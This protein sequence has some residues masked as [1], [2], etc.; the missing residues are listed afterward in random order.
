MSKLRLEDINNSLITIIKL[1][2]DVECKCIPH[3]KSLNGA[4]LEYSHH[5]ILELEVNLDIIWPNL[6]HYSG[7]KNSSLE[8]TGDLCQAKPPG[9]G[10][11]GVKGHSSE[12][13]C[14]VLFTFTHSFS[15]SLAYCGIFVFR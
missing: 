1:L 12:F 6:S 5:R 2:R 3:G 4:P 9:S 14:F 15:F 8:N 13:W 7:E 11:V 10:K